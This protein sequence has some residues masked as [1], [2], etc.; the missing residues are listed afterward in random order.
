ME[1]LSNGTSCCPIIPVLN[2]I[3]F[4]KKIHSG[5]KIVTYGVNLHLFDFRNY[6]PAFYFSLSRVM[7]S[8]LFLES[9]FKVQP[10]SYHLCVKMVW[11]KDVVCE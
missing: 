1:G 2:T 10:L 6:W 5:I 11:I 7:V 4:F 3:S 8:G 9:E